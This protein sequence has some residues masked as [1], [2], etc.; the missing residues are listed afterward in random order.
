MTPQEE[1]PLLRVRDLRTWFVTSRGIVR[2]ANRVSFDVGQ[3]QAIGIVGESGSGKTQSFLSAFALSTGYPGIVGGSAWFDGT[4]LL[5]GIEQ[6]YQLSGEGD[7]GAAVLRD[8]QPRW[9]REHRK[10][11]ERLLGAKIALMSQDPKRSLVPYWT[12]ERHLVHALTRQAPTGRTTTRERATDLLS[13]LGF[14]TPS[15]ILAAFPQQL[16]GGEAQRVMLALTMAIRPKLLIADEPTTALDALNQFRVLKELQRLH[17]STDMSLVLI[18][19]DIGVVQRV[20]SYLVVYLG[21]YVVE[22]API[23]HLSTATADRAHPYTLELMASQRRRSE[24]LPV[25]E[26]DQAHS[27]KPQR[28][29]PFSLRCAK[30]LQLAASMQAQCAAEMPPETSV[31]PDHVVACW[32]FMT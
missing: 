6:A 14:T 30:R 19:H 25:L 32:G 23:A 18:S 29:C 7:D 31:G 5:D 1:T 13:Q 22:R 3:G 10:R 26:A 17:D 2:A 20:A 28:G 21:G 4:S 9:R 16:S 8:I 24:G 12:V 11:A 27:A 15:R